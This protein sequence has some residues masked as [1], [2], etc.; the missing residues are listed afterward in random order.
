M[1]LVA[2]LVVLGAAAAW[3]LWLGPAM[4]T[5]EAQRKWVTPEAAKARQGFP[6]VS[7]EKMQLLMDA[8]AK[9]RAQHPMPQA[10]PPPP[11]DK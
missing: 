8:A 7:Q 4:A 5:A 6:Q 3:A 9:A 10:A 2:V 1:V 11:A